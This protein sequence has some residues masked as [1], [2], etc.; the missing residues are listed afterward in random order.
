MYRPREPQPRA[1]M[2]H[3]SQ[4]RT[5][6]RRGGTNVDGHV[7]EPAPRDERYDSE[8][9]RDQLEETPEEERY[10]GQGETGSYGTHGGV[11][12]GSPGSAW[13]DG[14]GTMAPTTAWTGD[15]M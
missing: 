13:R 8:T 6:G 1:A 4:R 15:P 9:E 11:T 5:Q 7:A 14:E 3:E 12:R 2:R 10:F